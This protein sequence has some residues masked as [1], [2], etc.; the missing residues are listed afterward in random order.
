MKRKTIVIF[1]IILLLPAC[2]QKTTPF[3][4]LTSGLEVEVFVGPMCPVMRVGEECPD[5]TYQATLT[6]LKPDGREYTKFETD[7]NGRYTIILP[8]GD[9]I[10]RPESPPDSPLPFAGEQNFTVLQDEITHLVVNYDSGI[11]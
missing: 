3:E 5:Q 8:P 9:Y 6:V 1:T 10:L 7:E 2:G 4:S 11:R